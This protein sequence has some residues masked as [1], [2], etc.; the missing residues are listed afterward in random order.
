MKTKDKIKKFLLH[1]PRKHS[2]RRLGTLAVA[3]G[4]IITIAATPPN[5]EAFDGQIVRLHVMANSNDARDQALKL[6]V[7]DHVLAV[8]AQSLTQL[9]DPA[10][11]KEQIEQSLPLIRKTAQDMVYLEGYHYGVQVEWGVFEFPLREYG[12]ITLPKGDYLAVR[13]IIGEGSGQ[14]WWCV[15]YPPLCFVNESKGNMP[16][17]SLT[18]LSKQTRDIIAAQNGPDFQ[19]KFKILE[20]LGLS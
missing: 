11:A 20:L 6:K 9:D 3:V 10:L 8:M 12:N 16:P 4:A 1:T 7:R 18:K 17:A 13:I 15:M 14:N 5:A 2:L 19:V